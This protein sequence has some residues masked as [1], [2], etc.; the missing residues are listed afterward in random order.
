M[1]G[2]QSHKNSGI[3]GITKQNS[4]E[5]FMSLFSERFNLSIFDYSSLAYCVVELFLDDEGQPKDWIY[6]YCNQA[7]ADIKEYR[8]EAMIDHSYLSLFPEA[9]ERYLQAYYEAAFEN[10]PGGIDLSINGENYHAAIMPIG[11]MGFCSCT[12]YSVAKPVDERDVLDK[13]SSEYVSIY[14]IELNSGEYEIL[15]LVA[16]TNARQLVESNKQLYSSFDEYVIEYAK[17]F[18]PV[19][20]RAEFF[21]NLTCKEMKR[22]LTSAEKLTYHY[23]SISRLGQDK[24][25][26]AY[27]VKGQ[28]DE[29]EFNIFL[30]FRNIDNIVYKEKE[31]QDKLQNALDE[32]RLGNEIISAIAKTYQYISRID[33]AADYFEEISNRDTTENNFIKSGTLSENNARVYKN[34]VDEEYQEA[35]MNFVNLK[36]LPERMAQEETIAIEYRT[37]SGNWHKL[38]FIEKKRDETGRLTNVLCVMR[39]ISDTKKTEENLMNQVA[40][41]KKDAALKTRFL[42]NMSHDIRTPINGILG[43]IDLSDHYP[44]DMEIQSRCRDKIK[45]MSRFLVSLV[46]DVLAINK[47][48]TIQDVKQDIEFDLAEM[49]NRANNSKQIIAAEKNIDYIVDWERSDMKHMYLIGNPLYVERI[50]LAIADNA[51][52]FTNAGGSVRVWCRELSADDEQVTYE[53]GCTDTGIGMSEGFVSHAFDMFSQENAT[54]R[55]RY[56]GTGLGLAI[57]KKL[58]DKLG[59]TIELQSRQGSGTTVLVKLTFKIASGFEEKADVRADVEAVSVD[60]LK[61]LVVEDNELNMEIVDFMLQDNGIIVEHAV[62]GAQA[63]EKFE[64]SEPGYYDVILMDIMMPNLN[65][66]DATRKIRSLDRADAGSI[67]IIAMSANAFAED[68]INSR[69]SGMNLHLTKPLSESKLIDAIRECL[70]AKENEM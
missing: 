24:F 63:V 37:K 57:A 19:D 58:A 62:D 28:V 11:R 34:V 12:L 36:T 26:E 65:G 20:E 40:E 44:Q 54:S 33:I 56:E 47:L 10:K 6:R 30:A 45:D 5:V 14:R 32:A 16:D 35:F 2:S 60:K 43:M 31:I 53:F 23:H 4:G 27:A 67:P 50:L 51:V 48:D 46:D 68:M 52:K 38:R 8:L 49:L 41:A 15:R 59:G 17:E 22:K 21:D 9:D 39:S 61:A 69:I 70:I 29:H 25:F 3:I 1:Y 13:L 64:N 66:W 7:F 55:T 42:S 18:I